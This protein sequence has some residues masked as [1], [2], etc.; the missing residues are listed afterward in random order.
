MRDEILLHFFLTHVMTVADGVT[1]ATSSS[2]IQYLPDHLFNQQ[3]SNFLQVHLKN[4][5]LAVK[6]STIMVSAYSYLY[7]LMYVIVILLYLGKKN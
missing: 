7:I 1:M 6:F 4:N 5:S 2:A 3:A